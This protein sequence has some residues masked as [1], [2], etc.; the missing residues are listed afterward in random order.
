MNTSELARLTDEQLADR[1]RQSGTPEAG[2]ELVRRH[3]ARTRAMIYA[4]VLNDAD[5]DDLAQEAMIK[6]LRGLAGYR[7]QARFSTWLYRIAMNTARTFLA[8]RAKSPIGSLA[9]CG[10]EPACAHTAERDI[11]SEELDREI[12][13]ALAALS[14][15]LR[16]AIVLIAI[17]GMEVVEAARVE[18]C[19][20]ATMYW[21]VHQARRLLR[22]HLGKHLTP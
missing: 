14:D 10:V 8:Q 17:Q 15:K 13:Q 6:A 2:D 12:R 4:M 19:A 11:R 9:E 7:G 3:L 18:N 5:A 21:R 20:T 16:A 1:Y 22:N